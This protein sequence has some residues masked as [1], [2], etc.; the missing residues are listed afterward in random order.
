MIELSD[1]FK[2]ALGTSR[3]T[4]VYPVLRI[5]KGVRLD[6]ENQ[7][8]EG[9]SDGVINLSIKSTTLKNF[10]GVYEN[11]E[12]LLIN[13]PSLTT[14]ADLINNKFTT[15]NMS[16]DISNYEYAGKKFSDNVV[17]YLKSVCQVFFVCN[18]I[19]SLED[20]LL[21]YTGTIR[22]FNQSAEST[23]LNLE[24][25]TQ[26]VLSIKVPSTLIPENVAQY[27]EKDFG[28]PYP[29]V[30]GNLDATPLIYNKYDRLEVDKPT[31]KIYGTWNEELILNT[32]MML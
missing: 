24:D 10:A 15:S 13:T 16:V 14:T 11:Y 27:D 23:I 6:E 29:A 28:K 5:Y 3:T 9:Q 19:D 26:Q 32:K 22:R 12:P 18:G 21:M 7:D 2:S 25:Y 31:Q 1:K 17:D 4:T 20:S 30:Y 8:F